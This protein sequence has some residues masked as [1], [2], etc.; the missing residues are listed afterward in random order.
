MNVVTDWVVT[1]ATVARWWC[2]IDNTVGAEV[3]TVAKSCCMTVTVT[4]TLVTVLVSMKVTM[5]D[6]VTVDECVGPWIVESPPA[7]LGAG[8]S[9]AAST[10]LGVGVSLSRSVM[11]SVGISSLIPKV[12]GVGTSCLILGTLRV[13]IWFPIAGTLDDGISSRL[14]A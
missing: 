1:T 12:L 8:A 6:V 7:A 13:G 4:S 10:G 3:A 11:L 9:F 2:R 5:M 14:Q